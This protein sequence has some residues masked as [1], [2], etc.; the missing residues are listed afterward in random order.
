MA[1]TRCC[2]EGLSRVWM[3]S[4]KASS[5]P[6]RRGR[7]LPRQASAERDGG[8][9]QRLRRVAPDSDDSLAALQLWLL[10]NL[11]ADLT[12]ATMAAQARLS[13]SFFPSSIFL[14]SIGA[15]GPHLQK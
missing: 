8:C 7:G 9:A 6:G 14:D 11:H 12:L 3:P 5:R 2:G 15:C 10:E 1:C 4:T 13:L